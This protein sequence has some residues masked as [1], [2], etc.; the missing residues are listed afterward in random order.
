MYICIY[1]L[2]F[3]ESKELVYCVHEIEWLLTVASICKL[4]EDHPGVGLAGWLGPAEPAVGKS[5]LA[6]KLGAQCPQPS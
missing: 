3:R 4:L 5:F 6:G 1:Y 2:I